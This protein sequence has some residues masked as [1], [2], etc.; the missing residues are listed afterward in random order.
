MARYWQGHFR[1]SAP[2]TVE[3]TIL[4]DRNSASKAATDMGERCPFCVRRPQ[5]CSRH[6]GITCAVRHDR[7]NGGKRKMVAGNDRL[8]GHR[9]VE[10][11][12][13]RRL[14]NHRVSI[15]LAVPAWVLRE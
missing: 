7:T 9:A 10:Q 15:D 14:G 6:E 13:P 2:M 1:L 8:V 5:L 12:A 3:S 11:S 4:V